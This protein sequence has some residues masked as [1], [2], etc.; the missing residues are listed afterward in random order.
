IDLIKSKFVFKRNSDI[1]KNINQSYHRYIFEDNSIAQ[2]LGFKIS[3]NNCHILNIKNFIEKE[4][5]YYAKLYYKI[6]NSNNEF[7]KYLNINELTG[8]YQI[9]LAACTMEDANEDRKIEIIAREYERLWLLLHLNG[10]YDSNEFQ[11]IS[12]ELNKKLKGIEIDRYEC[13]FDSILQETFKEKRQADKIQSLLEY[14]IF[15][16][17]DYANTNKRLLR[18][19]F[20][21]IEKYMC[22]QIKINPQNDI[23]YITTKTGDKTGYHIEHILSRNITNIKFFSNEEEF[24]SQRNILGGLL[25][26]K[27]KINISSSNEEYEDKL[28][29]YS[30]SLVW[31]HTLCESFYHKT[32]Q[33][34]LAFNERLKNEKGVSFK[35][36]DKFDKT[37]L[38]ERSRLLYELIKD[39][40]NVDR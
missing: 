9:I 4:I 26:L 30:N 8:Q 6:C 19:L 14:E 17:K 36:Y 5:K 35:P 15:I 27:D 29:T 21:R 24:D 25:L 38:N 1:E 33:Y 11:E 13:I 16:T 37:A 32:N 31:G 20:A 12:Y 2:G 39:I 3:G 7:L 22:E 10:I 18:Y 23:E 40:W 28:K 34:F